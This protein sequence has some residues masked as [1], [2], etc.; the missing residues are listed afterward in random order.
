MYVAT[1]EN[2]NDK[3]I[4]N[5]QKHEYIV[6]P[7]YTSRLQALPWLDIDT[8]RLQALPWLDIDTSRLQALPWLDIFLPN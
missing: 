5:K 3:K 7:D 8:S 6:P 4:K 1:K 2:N